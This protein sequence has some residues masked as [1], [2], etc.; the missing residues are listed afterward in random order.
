MLTPITSRLAKLDST[1][2]RT[3]NRNAAEGDFRLS[4][5]VRL[6]MSSDSL[7]E[8]GVHAVTKP[9]ELYILEA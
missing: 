4:D 8:R 1:E 6:C 7:E 2:E 5:G 9:P 3:L